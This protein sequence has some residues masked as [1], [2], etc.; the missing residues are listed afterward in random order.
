MST[1]T[2]RQE[3]TPDCHS[4]THS[5]CSLFAKLVG[6]PEGAEH[7]SWTA[8]HTL[9]WVLEANAPEFWHLSSLVT[10]FCW[11]GDKKPI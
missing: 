11:L 10:T 6:D 2:P 4:M 9:M 3:G 5:L 1:T 8:A 7:F